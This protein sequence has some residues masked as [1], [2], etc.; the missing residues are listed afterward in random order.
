MQAKIDNANF[1]KIWIV[2]A[3]T[4]VIICVASA[5]I[6]YTHFDSRISAYEK[7]HSAQITAGEEHEHDRDHHNVI[8]SFVHNGMNTTDKVIVGVTGTLI[9]LLGLGY[10][11]L[12]TFWMIQR[13]RK[14]GASPFLFGLL[15]LFFNIAAVIA[16]FIYRH[17][18][19]RCPDCG[20]IQKRDAMFC[21]YCGAPVSHIC[22]ECGNKMRI[23]DSYCRKCGAKVK[24]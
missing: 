9:G 20:K 2:F 23:S 19:I 1:K 11:L 3:V 16:Y 21:E 13:S 12:M 4:A 17:F 5:A 24:D 10:W 15:T 22:E 7:S 14:D 18:T 8:E 6:L